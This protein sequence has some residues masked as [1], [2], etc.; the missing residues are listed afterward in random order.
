MTT[1]V[2]VATPDPDDR[3]PLAAHNDCDASEVC[4]FDYRCDGY[5]DCLDYLGAPDE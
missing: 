3:A 1:S 5:L 4:E 2:L